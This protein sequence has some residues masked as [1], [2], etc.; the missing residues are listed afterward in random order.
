[1]KLKP[2]IIAL[3]C[4]ALLPRNATCQIFRDSEKF[5]FGLAIKLNLGIGGKRMSF[6]NLSVAAG[7]SRNFQNDRLN[8][9]PG[10]QLTVNYYSKGPGTSVIDH[11]NRNGHL[12]IVS[13]FYVVGGYNW[14]GNEREK[15][16]RTFNQMS[17][18]TIRHNFDGA[19]SYGTSFLVNNQGRNQQLGH[20]GF[21]VDQILVGYYND[22]FWPFDLFA[23]DSFDRYWTG[24][25]Y[26]AYGLDAFG[27]NLSR[28]NPWFQGQFVEYAYD[29]FTGN[30]QTGYK[31]S[32]EL[33][34]SGIPQKDMKQ[35]FYNR[36]LSSI[37]LRNING[38]NL[39]IGLLGQCPNCDVQDLLHRMLGYSRHVSLSKCLPVVLG[40][41]QYNQ[42]YNLL[43]KN[44]K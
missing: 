17:A 41:F 11:F 2:L 43:N 37:S 16:I 39:G 7:L 21:N 1:M 22:G 9:L 38:S 30:V 3:F 5:N 33:L 42:Y 35:A 34:F 12:D 32:K 20:M 19:I 4:S 10:G 29:R 23:G 15:F 14:G 18:T 31:L 28:K 44:P 40:S 27:N 36:A 13:T 6:Y 25:G 8:F 24:G 26:V